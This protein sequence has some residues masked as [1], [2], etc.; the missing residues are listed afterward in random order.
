MATLYTSKTNHV[1]RMGKTLKIY[2]KLQIPYYHLL[3]ECLLTVK[4]GN[5][6]QTITELQTSEI[7]ICP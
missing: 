7:I 4:V 1:P 6:G 3:N 5:Q 2:L